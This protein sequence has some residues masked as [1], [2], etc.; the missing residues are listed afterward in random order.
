MTY[1]R[2]TFSEHG[3]VLK[4][5]RLRYC[6]PSELDL[7][8][9]LAGMRLRERYADWDRSRSPPPSR[10]HVSVYEKWPEPA[11]QATGPGPRSDHFP[12]L[13]GAADSAH[14]PS[15]AAVAWAPGRGR[16]SN[17]GART[18][19]TRSFPPS[20]GI[21]APVVARNDAP[22]RSATIRPTVALVTS[23]RSRFRFLYSSGV[24]P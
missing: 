24:R 14:R 9:R 17:P 12:L 23:V 5:L 20:T 15:A 7:M 4:P 22:H 2:V 1:Q 10:K 11:P 19:T 16:A 13:S 8:A 6:W 21:C 18:Q 3:T